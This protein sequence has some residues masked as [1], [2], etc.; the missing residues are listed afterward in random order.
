MRLNKFIDQAGHG[1]V[2]QRHQIKK[3]LN[4][5]VKVIKSG[6]LGYGPQSLCEKSC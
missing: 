5:E 6:Y 1:C 2:S 3:I 4:T